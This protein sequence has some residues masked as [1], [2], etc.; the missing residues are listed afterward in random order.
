MSKIR[1]ALILMADGMLIA[2][3]V[4]LL[5][6]DRIVNGT[7]Y[8]YGLV[9]SNDWAQPYWLAFRVSL[10]LLIVVLL[11]VT[12]VELPGPIFQKEALE[13]A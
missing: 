10:G 9:F 8:S 7:L 1:L 13:E 11:L 2:V 6:I 5:Q 12:I 3:L 4:L